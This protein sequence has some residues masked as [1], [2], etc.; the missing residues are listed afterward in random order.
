MLF[1]FFL[2]QVWDHWSV[3]RIRI[4]HSCLLIALLTSHIITVYV[5]TNN[6]SD[7]PMNFKCSCCFLCKTKDMSTKW[8]CCF[9][10]TFTLWNVDVNPGQNAE[11]STYKLISKS[12]AFWLAIV[13]IKR[14]SATQSKC[15][16]LGNQFLICWVFTF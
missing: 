8:L 16:N 3:I 2:L 7:S 4:A 1:I 15:S 11:I 13:G 10:L 12:W 6:R 5:I 14:N 9:T